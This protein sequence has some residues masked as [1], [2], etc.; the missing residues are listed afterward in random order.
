METTKLIIKP[1]LQRISFLIMLY[2]LG[3]ALGG[4]IG[5]GWGGISDGI[6]MGRILKFATAGA[7]G[8]AIG[9]F[10]VGIVIC[11]LAFQF[12]RLEV[13]DQALSGPSHRQKQEQFRFSDVAEFNVDTSILGNYRITAR[14]GREILLTKMYFTKDQFE[15]V[16]DI[17]KY[18]K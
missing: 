10:I 12:S 16:V 15:K 2:T 3:V 5:A 14:D 8:G 4:F 17:I 7:A 9:G 13:Y 18:A 11:G 6:E 1:K